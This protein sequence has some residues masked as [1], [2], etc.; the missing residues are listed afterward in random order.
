MTIANTQRAIRMQEREAAIR[1]FIRIWTETKGSAPTTRHIAI[2]LG[3]KPRNAL[4]RLRAM[5]R[6]GQLVCDH[7]ASGLAHHWRLR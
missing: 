6:K 3:L 2:G 4:T 7:G 5:I 1:V